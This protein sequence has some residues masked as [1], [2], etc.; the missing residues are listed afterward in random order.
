LRSPDVNDSRSTAERAADAV[1]AV[2]A[3]PAKTRTA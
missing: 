3:Q 2:L 1:L